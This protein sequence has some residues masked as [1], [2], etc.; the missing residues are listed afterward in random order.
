[1][2]A[3]ATAMPPNASQPRYT[4]HIASPGER[5][6]VLFNHLTAFAYFAWIPVVP[7]LI[8]WLIKRKE[9]PFLDDHGR[10]AVNFQI[11]LVIYS[12]LLLPVVAVITCGVGMV[13]YLPLFALAAIGSIMAAIAANKGEYYRYPATIR[14]LS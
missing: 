6:Y 2:G 14:L 10:E 7:A 12:A 3:W 8:M 4:D 5:T 1:M 9:S 13:L 11:S